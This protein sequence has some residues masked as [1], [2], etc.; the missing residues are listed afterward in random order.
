MESNVRRGRIGGY[1][2]VVNGIGIKVLSIY[3]IVYLLGLVLVYLG[4][5]IR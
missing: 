5:G 3:L 4:F 1:G 2:W